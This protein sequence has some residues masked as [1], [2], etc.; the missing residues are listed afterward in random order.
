[1]TSSKNHNPLVRLF[2]SVLMTGLGL[3]AAASC[4]SLVLEDR[5]VCP[6]WVVL[7]NSPSV[8]PE[9][10]EY[11]K[12]S[13][14]KDWDYE[15]EGE[16]GE[17]IVRMD[18]LN[19]GHRIAWRKEHRFDVTGITGWNGTID[20]E[21]NYL[22]PFGTECPDA[23]G[24]YV[25][26]PIGREEVYRVDFPIRSLFAN[27]FI[28]IQGAASEYAFKAGIRGA[29]DGY[30]FPYLHLHEG[31][32]ECETRQLDYWIRAARIPRQDE[33]SGIPSQ[34]PSGTR[35]VYAAGLKVDFFFPIYG[36]DASLKE[37]WERFYTLPLGEIITL[38]GYSWS[39]AVL[40]DIHVKIQLA[41]GGIVRLEVSVADWTVVVIG[42]DGQK[43]VI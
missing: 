36:K 10:W 29:V 11:M 2:I 39:D 24:G 25:Q 40:E 16:A 17:E 14:W 4:R 5:S 1:M 35:T 22:I 6:T 7:K 9:R 31:P 3:C 26:A 32:F 21:G 13:Y 8:S 19:E 43:Y 18:A 28:E 41:D 23:I 30:S 37:N 38:N 15:A 12:L 20:G 42:D 27:V 33:P 34:S